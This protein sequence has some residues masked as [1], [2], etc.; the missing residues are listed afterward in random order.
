[1]LDRI[2]VHIPQLLPTLFRGPHIE[3]IETRLPERRAGTPRPDTILAEDAPPAA[4]FGGACPEPV[5][6]W[7]A[8]LSEATGRTFI[9]AR[10]A[11]FTNTAPA[12]S[13]SQ[14]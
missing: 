9:S 2:A 5:E 8:I 13:V 6:G 1:L 7:A 14:S 3:I 12:S 4:V 11:S 10:W